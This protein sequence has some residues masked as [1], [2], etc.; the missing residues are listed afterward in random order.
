[1][2]NIS[3][4]SK[5]SSSNRHW[6]RSNGIEIHYWPHLQWLHFQLW[7]WRIYQVI[8]K[9]VW[10]LK[11]FKSDIFFGFQVVSTMVQPLTKLAD[12]SCNAS[13]LCS[14]SN[15][16]RS[17]SE[18]TKTHYQT[19][20]VRFNLKKNW[21]IGMTSLWVWEVKC[22]TYQ[23]NVTCQKFWNLILSRK[24]KLKLRTKILLKNL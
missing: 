8:K 2:E 3:S 13:W 15:L 11:K 5:W 21:S 23:I 9:S 10:R 20:K 24:S 1:M 18:I 7:V 12:F 4:N 17:Q 16:W 22:Q 6:F 14:I 19:W